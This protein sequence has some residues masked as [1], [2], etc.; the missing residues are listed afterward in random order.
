METIVKFIIIKENLIFIL[1]IMSCVTE[2]NFIDKK[3][4]HCI[5]FRVYEKK[6][7][8]VSIN[9][10]LEVIYI[11]PIK[12]FCENGF[13]SVSLKKIINIIKVIPNNSYIEFIKNNE[14]LLI[15][16]NYLKFRICL[17][18][19]NFFYNFTI[20]NDFS[21][22]ISSLQ[23]QTIYKKVFFSVAENDVRTYLNG[24]LFD[25]QENLLY[26]VSSDGHRLSMYKLNFLNNNLFFKQIIISGKSFQN[27][28]NIFQKSENIKVVVYDNYIKF[29]TENIIVKTNLLVGKYPEYLNLL[30]NLNGNFLICNKQEL[31]DIF[32]RVSVLDKK[33]D[34]IIKMI[35]INDNLFLST[36]NNIKEYVE[37][38]TKI[39]YYDGKDIT[40]AFNAKYIIDILNVVNFEFVLMIISD[41]KSAVI[42]ESF[43]CNIEDIKFLKNFQINNLRKRN[44][45]IY[46][47]MPIRL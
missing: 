29:M 8:V 31:L 37:D 39:V 21:F 1:K 6:L 15:N 35:L 4:D 26:V 9:E 43:D 33:I 41:S 25:L 47:L 11:Y 17:S 28:V 24:I 44:D 46:I 13:F 22:Y 10:F 36:Y 12:E 5:F 19:E 2:K 7:I 23:L 34:C 27:I 38:K 16:I 3:S 20:N 45:S 14:E 18:S 30:N 40:L 32:L 42:V